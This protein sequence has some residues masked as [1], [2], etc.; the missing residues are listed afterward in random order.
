MDPGFVTSPCDQLWIF[1]GDARL[2][3]MESK[4]AIRL[5]RSYGEDLKIASSLYPLFPKPPGKRWGTPIEALLIGSFPACAGGYHFLN[6]PRVPYPALHAASSS[7]RHPGKAI[8]TR[9]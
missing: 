1:S 3:R 6:P 7:T 4:S 5:A 9:G 8:A 2:M